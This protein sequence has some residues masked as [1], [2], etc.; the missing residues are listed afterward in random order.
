MTNLLLNNFQEDPIDQFNL[1]GEIYFTAPSQQWIF[2]ADLNN[3]N[4]DEMLLFHQDGDSV[5]LF[6]PI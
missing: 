6:L 3:D 4:W 5:F 1:R 2:F